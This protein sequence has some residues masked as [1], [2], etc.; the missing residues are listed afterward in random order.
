MDDFAALTERIRNAKVLQWKLCN[1]V[2]KSSEDQKKEVFTAIWLNIR[3]EFVG[4]IRADRPFFVRLSSAQT[5][6]GTLNLDGGTRLPYN[7]SAGYM[8]WYMNKL[9]VSTDWLLY[10][11]TVVR[12]DAKRNWYW[13]N[14]SLFWDIFIMVAFQ[15][16]G[17]TPG[18]AYGPNNNIDP[19]IILPKAFVWLCPQEVIKASKNI[20]DGETSA[21]PAQLEI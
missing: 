8:Y 1:S 13:R 7:L 17:G 12:E 18:Y 20:D 19:T 6:R 9:T 2:P 11:C 4:F 14:R 10:A 15:S 3:L 21:I 5:S 16:G